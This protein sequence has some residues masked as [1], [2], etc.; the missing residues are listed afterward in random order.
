MY[1]SSNNVLIEDQGGQVTNVSVQLVQGQD[2]SI[3]QF[4]I[5][6]K[7]FHKRAKYDTL[8]VLG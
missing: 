8:K 4:W 6:L 1:I 3:V 2:H 5:D 7:A